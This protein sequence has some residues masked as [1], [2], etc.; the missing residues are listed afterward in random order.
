MPSSCYAPMSVWLKGSKGHLIRSQRVLH[1]T[2]EVNQSQF[3]F[4][5]LLCVYTVAVARDISQMTY[6]ELDRETASS[7]LLESGLSG[8]EHVLFR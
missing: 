2:R 1:S 8:D 5:G 4:T 6:P 7:V 3:V